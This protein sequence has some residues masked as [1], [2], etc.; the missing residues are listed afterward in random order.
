MK[1]PMQFGAFEKLILVIGSAIVGMVIGYGLCIKIGNN[2][3]DKPMP[4]CAQRDLPDAG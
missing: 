4:E 2:Q 1:V 3:S